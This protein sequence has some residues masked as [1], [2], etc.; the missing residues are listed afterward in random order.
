VQRQNNTAPTI[1]LYSPSISVETVDRE[2][3]EG[4]QNEIETNSPSPRQ[5]FWPSDL[6][7][8]ALADARIFTW[9]YD[10]DVAKIFS[11][12]SQSSVS[13]HAKQL[14]AD[15]VAVSVTAAQKQR[16]IV[17]VVH[18]LGGLVKDVLAFSRM[19]KT[20]LQEI[21]PAVIGICFLGT[22][23]RASISTA[24]FVCLP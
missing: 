22:P 7:S 8:V 10:A 13:Q 12:A 9:G 20:Y 6:L 5:I 17:F 14:L 19:T 23:H 1:T 18:S 3:T 15:L 11:F 16:P 4:L 24:G 21:W 2:E